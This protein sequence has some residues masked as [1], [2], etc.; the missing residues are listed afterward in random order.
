MGV[1]EPAN[2]VAVLAGVVRLVLHGSTGKS[3]FADVAL[4]LEE[5]RGR[6]GQRPPE[7]GW[8]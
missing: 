7:P 4:N 1:R 5:H 3:S 6:H 8:S 2:R